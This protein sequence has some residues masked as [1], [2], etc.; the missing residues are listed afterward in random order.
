MTMPCF[1]VPV[2]CCRPAMLFLILLFC[3]QIWGGVDAYAQA[4]AFARMGFGS[5]GVAL[6]N[7]LVA[8]VYG[9]ASPYYNPALAPFIDR[10]NLEATAAIFTLDRELQFLQFVA[11]LRPRA[12]VAGGL[13]HAG[14][15]EIDGRDAS[16]YHTRDYSTDEFAFFLAFGTRLSRR[17]TGGFGLQLFQSA[18]LEDLSPV[19]AIGVDVG[20][21]FQATE[22]L[23]LGF[24]ADD[25]LARYVWDRSSLGGAGGRATDRFPRR[26]RFGA[27]YRL[28]EA[29]T[30]L[31]AEYEARIYTGEFV[32]RRTEVI[33]D[34]PVERTYRE[35]VRMHDGR[36]RLG[37]E[38]R[39]SV[40]FALRAG[41][42]Q[43]G[44]SGVKPS[45]GFMVEQPVGNLLLRGEYAFMLEPYGTSP[46]HFI[47]LRLYLTQ[48]P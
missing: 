8:D 7:A 16:G 18:L 22:A 25:L 21:A 47:T 41:V 19:R 5:R 30:W 28:E 9:D 1:Q 15:S 45:A 14:V 24:T 4:G 2:L 6:S 43:I 34:T 36:L 33:V 32:T 13:I 26:L 23:S 39:P 10:Q 31:F 12:G 35:L 46:M 44:A 27:G 37:A 42:D 29:R 11:P 20:L 48:E 3:T 17:L 38:Y 40:T